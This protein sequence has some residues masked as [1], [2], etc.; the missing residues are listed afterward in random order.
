M[1]TIREGLRQSAA[2]LTL[3]GVEQGD[4]EAAWLLAH[5]MGCTVGA[6][7]ARNDQVLPP[8]LAEAF[9]RLTGRRAVR[10]PLQYILG[11]EE[12]MGRSFKVT[13]AVLIPR[14]DTEVLVRQ[15]LQRLSGAVRIAD[16]GTGS[17]IIAITMAK[18]LPEATIVA[19]DV[20]AEA[21]A[22]ARENAEMQGVA[23]RIVFRLGDLLQPLTGHTFDAILSNPPY[24]AG[25]EL[26]ALMPE[27]RL[28]EPPGALSPGTDGLLM[29]RRLAGGAPVLLKPGG[30]LGVEVGA[31]QAASVRSLFEAAKLRVAVYPDAAGIERAVFGRYE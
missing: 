14:S 29:Y 31:G 7:R 6:L 28:W 2:R 25:S 18:W 26:A 9:S 19:V 1:T 17:G 13:P 24:V 3:A 23:D 5:L 30:I 15:A 22:V 10:E 4:R 20:S 12:F 21:L 16:V 27:V 11:S 8:D